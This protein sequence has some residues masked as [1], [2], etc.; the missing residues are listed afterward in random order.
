MRYLFILLFLFSFSWARSQEP[1][2]L[3]KKELKFV[4]AMFSEE[5]YAEEISIQG[6]DPVRS[7]SILEG[8]HVYLVRKEDQLNGYLLSTS[9]LGRYD[10]FDYL[11]AYAPDLSI[12]G[13]TVTAY[14]SSHG[15]AICQKKWLGQFDGYSGE[16]LTLGKEIDAV[17]GATISATSMVEDVQRCYRLMSSLREAG[18]MD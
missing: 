16:E 10:F 15:A 8:D 2:P 12:L 5:A 6:Q 3:T 17:A 13:M 4:K 9:A 1:E 11:V 7:G 14:R 18:L